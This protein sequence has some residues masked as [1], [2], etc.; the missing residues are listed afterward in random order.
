MPTPKLV[1]KKFEAVLERV[2]N[3]LNWTIARVP[4]EVSKAW[5]VRGQLRVKGEINGFAFRTSLFPTRERGHMMM[6][7]KQVQK[8][9]GV[10]AGMKARFRLEP[11]TEKREMPPSPELE[12]VLKQSKTLKKFHDSLSFSMRRDIARWINEGKQAETRKR[13]AEQLAERL[14]LAMEGE[15]ELP[16]VLQVALA[17]N[18]KARAGWEL[19]PPG[20][21][22]FHLLGIFGY[23]N[24]ESQAR[25]I[26][27]AME[28]MVE[29]AEK[30]ERKQA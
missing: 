9:S 22:R 25:R 14:M 17:R 30:Q 29:C 27:K 16:P 5:G 18:P 26:A 13:R 28:A 1:I 8:G 19:M 20:Q 4:P 15:R 21:R 3:R 12:R 11:D 24:P 10:R 7:N 23:R 2:G 6:V